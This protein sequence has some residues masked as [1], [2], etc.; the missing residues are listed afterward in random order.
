MTFE[1]VV[2]DVVDYKTVCLSLSVM[3]KQ[4]DLM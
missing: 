2:G 4:A 1:H 3:N